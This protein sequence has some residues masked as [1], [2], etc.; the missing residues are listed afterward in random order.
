MSVASPFA[1]ARRRRLSMCDVNEDGRPKSDMKG[2]KCPVS[3]EQLWDDLRP[4]RRPPN[5]EE[6]GCSSATI[7]LSFLIC[8]LREC[9]VLVDLK[10]RRD[11]SVDMGCEPDVG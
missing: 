3:H 11:I 1:A 5:D 7:F 10:T 9:F 6:K 8:L 2:D 4:Q